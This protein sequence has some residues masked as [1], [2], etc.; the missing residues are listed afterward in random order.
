MVAYRMRCSL[1]MTIAALL[2]CGSPAAPESEAVSTAPAWARAA[3]VVLEVDLDRG[4]AVVVRDGRALGRG[5]VAIDLHASAVRVTGIGVGAPAGLRRVRLSLGVSPVLSGVSLGPSSVVATPP[6]QR[7]ITVIPHDAAV[8]EASGGVQVLAGTQVQVDM[9]SR[10]R[11]MPSAEF[12]GDGS[13]GAGAPF[14]FFEQRRCAPAT[15]NG[16]CFRYETLPV[17]STAPRDVSFDVEPQ[18]RRFRARLLV[19]ADATSP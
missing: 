5:E 3:E 10:G 17:G 4:V 1:W 7:G 11:V 14:P 2:G 19:A 16:A 6:G 13:P 9:P 18:V 12:N 15:P 8:V